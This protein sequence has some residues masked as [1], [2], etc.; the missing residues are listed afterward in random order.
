MNSDLILVNLAQAPNGLHS[1]G[2]CP[3]HLR[4]L[5]HVTIEAFEMEK[6]EIMDESGLPILDAFDYMLDMMMKCTWD[7]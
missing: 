5:G 3:L 6:I 2:Q 7:A 4:G 1:T